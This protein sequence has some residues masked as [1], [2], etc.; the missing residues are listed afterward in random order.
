MRRAQLRRRYWPR[1]WSVYLHSY[2]FLELSYQRR[3][4][5]KDVRKTIKRVEGQR[6]GLPSFSLRLST[7]CRPIWWSL[8]I[9]F[10]KN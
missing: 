3:W 4:L 1:H 2:D 5:W 6:L 8:T 9:P 10:R 7:S